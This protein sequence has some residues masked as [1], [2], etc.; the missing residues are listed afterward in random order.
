MEIKGFWHKEGCECFFSAF[1]G[2]PWIVKFHWD[3]QLNSLRAKWSNG[4]QPRIFLRKYQEAN[5]SRFTGTISSALV[6]QQRLNS[7]TLDLLGPCSSSV[8]MVPETKGSCQHCSVL[9]GESDPF[10]A[11]WGLAPLCRDCPGWPDR[12]IIYTVTDW[13]HMGAHTRT[14]KDC[15]AYSHLLYIFY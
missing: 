14:L 13:L 5:A 3:W 12:W 7:M 2:L 1:A 9:F 10:P 8:K 6:L 11:E 15:V 4:K